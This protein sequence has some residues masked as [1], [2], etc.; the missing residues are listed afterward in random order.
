MLFE[1]TIGDQAR[2][3]NG[4]YRDIL[5]S[6]NANIASESLWIDLLD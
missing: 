5:R 2:K 4:C 3:I 1:D 6:R